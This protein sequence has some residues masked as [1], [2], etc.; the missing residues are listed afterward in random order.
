M[1]T[2]LSPAT[3]TFHFSAWILWKNKPIRDPLSPLFLG[4]SL[5]ILRGRETDQWETDF[6]LMDGMGTWERRGEGW[7]YM[8]AFGIIFW[9]SAL[10]LR[11]F[12]EVEISRA[13][14]Q[15]TAAAKSYNYLHRQT[16]QPVR[17]FC[18]GSESSW[19]RPFVSSP[20]SSNILRFINSWP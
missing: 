20:P 13:E 5:K 4:N 8:G 16:P 17:T 14:P 19:L 9:H 1:L 12:F 11:L 18:T 15:F 7:C 10:T 6:A 2:V 3:P